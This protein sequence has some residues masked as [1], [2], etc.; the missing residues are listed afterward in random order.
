MR[1]QRNRRPA[2][3]EALA[4][5]QIGDA[6]HAVGTDEIFRHRMALDSEAH[7]GQKR[8]GFLGRRRIV[9]RRR[10]RRHLHDLAQELRLLRMMGIDPAP[11]L[12]MGIHGAG[13]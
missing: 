6:L 3:P 5:D 1:V 10:V 2:R 11:E 9:A 8:C 4:D 7:G 13:R 12:V